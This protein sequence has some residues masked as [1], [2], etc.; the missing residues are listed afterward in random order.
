MLFHSNSPPAY[1]F[2]ACSSGK[3]PLICTSSLWGFL[4]I[5]ALYEQITFVYTADVHENVHS[6]PHGPAVCI[7]VLLQ[8]FPQLTDSPE[9][10]GSY[11][12]PVCN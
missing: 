9:K 3:P 2:T 6:F 11:F 1:S 5:I 4:N 10:S 7:A 12:L 8:R